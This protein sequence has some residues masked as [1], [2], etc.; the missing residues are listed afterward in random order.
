ML[1]ALENYCSPRDNEVLESHR[2][3]NT[4]HQEPFDKFLTELKT[5]AASCNSQE[6]D[7]M[8]RDKI[9]FT[10]T[11][12]LQELL[13]RV[14]VLTLEKAVKVY[15]A[16][17]QSN[18]SSSATKV[19]KV[20]QKLPL[21]KK[22]EGD[23]R[24]K[25]KDSEGMNVNCNFCGFKHES[26]KEKCPAWGKTCDRCKGRNHFKAKCKKVH[27]VT[28]FQGDSCDYV[29]QW[30]MAGK[31]GFVNATL[32]VNEQDVQFQLDSAADVNT[33]CQKYV[34]KHQVFPTK[35]RLNL[36]VKLF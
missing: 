9:V 15:R 2:F 12:K 10:V 30:L 36:W 20:S 29:D 21:T 23:N 1:E 22:S 25:K 26:N 18:S 6:K 34:R 27:A 28:H 24:H 5:K 3:W 31:E 4:P 8:M 14:D 16:H 33:I 17:E 13:F 11:G 32:T 35:V 19:S 7:R